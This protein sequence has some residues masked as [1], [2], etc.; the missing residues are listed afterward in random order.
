[1]TEV[2][3]S[4]RVD[5]GAEHVVRVTRKG[6]KVALQVDGGEWVGGAGGDDGGDGDTGASS[7]SASTNIFVGGHPD[8]TFSPAGSLSGATGFRGCL[9]GLTLRDRVVDFRDDPVRTGNV[10]PCQG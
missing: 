8:L 1:M 6:R 7:S 5:D 2:S 9:H 3:G 4:T 10:V